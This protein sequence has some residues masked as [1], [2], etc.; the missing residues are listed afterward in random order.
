VGRHARTAITIRLIDGCPLRAVGVEVDAV[1]T[2][3][4]PRCGGHDRHRRLG[5][6][7]VAGEVGDRRLLDRLLLRAG[8]RLQL[9]TPRSVALARLG[10]VA[11]DL[12]VTHGAR[13]GRR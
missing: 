7:M 5:W 10:A 13:Q 1:P 6:Q 12:G 8:D 9:T 4:L 2:G 3:L 11:L